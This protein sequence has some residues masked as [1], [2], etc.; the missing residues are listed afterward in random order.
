MKNIQDYLC[1]VDKVGRRFTGRLLHHQAIFCRL[2]VRILAIEKIHDDLLISRIQG[3]GSAPEGSWS[4][5]ST[6]VTVD[7][8]NASMAGAPEPLL[9][10][11]PVWR[12]PQMSADGDQDIEAPLVLDDPDLALF[13]QPL[14]YAIPEITQFPDLKNRRRF[15]ENLREHE[16]IGPHGRPPYRSQYTSP[17][18]QVEKFSPAHFSGLA[19]FFLFIFT[20]G[21]EPPGYIQDVPL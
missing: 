5:A 9:I 13:F 2:R 7:I 6:D 14:V 10:G 16:L 11:E 21:H 4:G 19:G 8:I 17:T 18:N 12:A 15:I 20:H 3:D 1:Q